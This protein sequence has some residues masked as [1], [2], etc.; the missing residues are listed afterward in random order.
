MLKGSFQIWI[1]VP[2][3]FLYGVLRILCLNPRGLAE[4]GHD[5]ERLLCVDRVFAEQ[6]VRC[7]CCRLAGNQSV[8]HSPDAPVEMHARHAQAHLAPGS[9]HWFLFCCLS[10][11][12]Y[13]HSQKRGLSG[14]LFCLSITRRHM[15]K[16]SDS[17]PKTT[18]RKRSCHSN[19]LDCLSS[20]A[21]KNLL[22]LIN[23]RVREL[24]GR[25]GVEIMSC[26]VDRVK[27]ISRG[28]GENVIRGGD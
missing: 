22:L 16:Q 8:V 3:S 17:F 23:A 1:P 10:S 20:L 28:K 21:I 19:W 12:I 9:K 27:A 4:K 24:K 14:N 11:T 18:Y 5:L 2:T 7:S 26:F 13:K 15:D 25:G 6:V